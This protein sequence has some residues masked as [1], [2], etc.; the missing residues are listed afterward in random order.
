MTADPDPGGTG[1]DAADTPTTRRPGPRPARSPDNTSDRLVEDDEAD[2]HTEEALR[3]VVRSAALLAD[4]PHA[5]LHLAQDRW[6]TALASHGLA[7]TPMW[8]QGT[9]CDQVIADGSLL[10][11]EDLQADARF[12]SH[13]LAA[14]PHALRA[15]LGLPLRI[16]GEAV[17]TLAV[18][19][20]RPR[21]PGPGAIAAL[22]T[23][24]GTASE[25]LAQRRTQDERRRLSEVSDAACDWAWELDAELRYVWISEPFDSV[26]GA[27]RLEWLGQGMGDA[28]LLDELGRPRA[29]SGRLADLLARPEA[30]AR[31]LTMQTIGWRKRY[32]SRSGVPLLD[33]QGRVRG[34]RGRTRDLTARMEIGAIAA[35]R[36][37]R[38]LKLSDHIPGLIF[39]YRLEADG[40]SSF[41]FA[42]GQLR[43]SLGF[44]PAP[45]AGGRPGQHWH[46]VHEDDRESF[47]R[48]IA[49]SARAL[50]PFE[51]EYRI[52][53]DDGSV[54][55]IETRATPERLP[56]GATLWHGFGADVTQRKQTELRLRS[57]EQQW[58]L[59]AEANGIGL[60][61]LDL[62]RGTMCFDQRACAHHGLPHPS[63]S[64]PLDDWF[65]AM[66]EADRLAVR[67]GLQRALATRS[68]FERRY[69][70]TRPDGSTR[71][72]ELVARA[73]YD[74]HD[75]PVGLVGTSRDVTE[76]VE[77]ERLRRDKETAERANRAKTEFLSRVSHELRTPLNGILGF[78]QL[79]ALDGQQPLAPAQR[80]RL[81]S[82]RAAGQHLLSLIEDMLDLT[83]IEHGAVR[84]QLEP[85]DLGRAITRSLTL[86][87][88]L[89]T[90]HGVC[91]PDAPA[92]PCWV[93]AD[94]RALDQVLMNL[95]SN[96]IKYNR[97]GGSVSLA[98]ERIGDRARLEIAD[99][100]PGL[101]A[102]Q[103]EGLFEPF[104]RLGAERRR[105][106]GTGL[107]LVI[108]RELS[109]TMGGELQLARSTP[110]GTCFRLEL[111]LSDR[112]PLALAPPETEEPLTTAAAAPRH[113]LYIE[114]EPLNVLLMEELVRARPG[115]SLH[116]AGDGASGLARA[117]ELRPDL[118]L[119]DMNLPDT[120]GLALIRR[121]R[122]DPRTAALPCI[123]LSADAMHE[124]VERAR[125]A[126]FDDYW[127]KPIDAVEMLA[128]LARV[129]GAA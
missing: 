86:T 111:P 10:L 57:T 24:A 50:A 47:V 3:A 95:V 55:W 19:D 9:P 93:L 60:A 103:Q 126:G 109:R 129:L 53:R 17:G 63:P 70:L 46:L 99:Q 61:S 113:V 117:T 122:D 74:A 66:D 116:V 31:A 34:W 48:A 59:A 65:A 22:T 80:L 67:S 127:T 123:A 101:S 82:V 110:L 30:F 71:V 100:G 11:V 106:E 121:L 89:A 37:E 44:D 52:R 1:S 88:P 4:M 119:V 51:R 78:T 108:A 102:S 2:A 27:S 92:A 73:S 40:R 75:E 104:N 58:E 14:P 90:R 26:T 105:I 8:R 115:W 18:L 96:A 33:A 91:L 81:E 7:P 16:D 124:Q 54:R 41:P 125:A 32:L 29:D 97:E 77:G 68:V 64:W 69:R 112:P 98:I 5:R 85:V 42:S 36:E 28:P 128:Q 114:D 25:L 23:L 107:G 39:Q 13:P 56:D 21:A 20:T 84:P 62:E 45:G 76:Q 83:R 35:E 87:E 12:R 118:V 38:L 6:L 120:H 72:L 15:Y 43:R 49:D 94:A 79:M